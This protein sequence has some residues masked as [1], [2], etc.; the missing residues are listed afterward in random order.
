[1]RQGK[2]TAAFFA[3]AVFFRILYIFL[4]PPAGNDHEMIHTAVDNLL[5]GNGLSYA[6][7]SA[8]DLSSTIYQPM[9]E[10]PPLV[11]Y[12]LS[13]VKAMTGSA[14]AT[15]MILM[16]IGMMLLLVVLHAIMKLLRLSE[17]TRIILWIIIAANPDPFRGVGISDLYSALFMVWGVLFCIRFMM[18]QKV[19]TMQLMVASVFFFLPAAF[20]YQYYPLIFL[21]PFLLLGAGKIKKDINLFRKGL[22]SLSIVF[23]LLCFQIAMLYQHTGTGSYIVDDKTGFYPQNLMWA[24]PFLLKSF[25]NTSYIETKL[26]M[27]GGQNVLPY[28]ALCFAVTLLILTTVFTYLVKQVRSFKA[29]KNDHKEL[30]KLSRFSLFTVGASVVLLLTA[31]SLYY[32]MQHKAMFTYVREG[33]YFIVSSLLFLLLFASL[34]QSFVFKLRF[35][36]KLP[37]KK[38]ALASIMIINLSLFGKFLYNSVTDNLKDTAG[39]RQEQRKLVQHEIE[40]LITKYKLPVVAASQNRDLIYYPNIKDYGIV[41]NFKE[42]FQN[43]IHT[44]QPVQLILVTSRKLT[45]EETTFVEQRGAREIKSNNYHRIFHLITSN[46]EAIAMLY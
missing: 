44:S 10:W 46:K 28:Y 26:L 35:N 18:D 42:L 33:R 9:T 24:H 38:L 20:R 4:Y 13:A 43:G 45:K 29:D 15:D 30:V 2:T 22:L 23:F 3:L 1:M 14:Y 8:N 6:I 7:A 32:D 31:L 19:S 34:A 11:A 17:Q 39:K 21:F 37:V 16:S 36:W 25:F 40:S 5:S 41:K 12:L 27:M